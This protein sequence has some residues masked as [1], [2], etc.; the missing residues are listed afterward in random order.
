MV[1]Y[2][3]E[4][5]GGRMGKARACSGEGVSTGPSVLRVFC[6]FLKN[7]FDFVQRGREKDSEKHR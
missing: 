6:C 7:I 2:E 4:R 3:R 1:T 5:G